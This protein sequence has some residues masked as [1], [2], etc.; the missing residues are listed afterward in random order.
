MIIL[1][2]VQCLPAN[3]LAPIRSALK[4]LVDHFGATV[5]FCTATQPAHEVASP[6]L[7]GIEATSILPGEKIA[8][9][10]HALKRVQWNVI[11]ELWSWEKV[12][13]EMAA[14]PAVP[15]L[16][17][18]NTR[19]Q[20][21]DLIAALDKAGMKQ[22]DVLHLSTLLCP[23]H[24]RAVIA[25]IKQRLED[26]KT[27]KEKRPLFLISTTV[28]EAGVD[29]SFPRL[30]RALGPLERI[31]QAAGRCNRHGEEGR[32]GGEVIIFKPEDAKAPK[33]WYA[34]CLQATQAMINRGV[35]EFDDPAVVTAYFAQLFGDLGKD[36]GEEISKAR[37][38]LDYEAVAEKFKMIQQDT[39]DVFVTGYHPKDDPEAAQRI[40]DK[41]ERNGEMT[42]RL[43]REASPFVVSLYSHLVKNN[44]LEVVPGFRVWKGSY[45][46][47]LGIPLN[48]DIS[49]SGPSIGDLIV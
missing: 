32:E 28:I 18:V 46:P 29:L 2:E 30:F 3:L 39:V 15:T 20:A 17:V 14:K 40:L 6:W 38:G 27:Q 19:Q 24:R 23:K 10:F 26:N 16:C 25:E 42:R 37:R 48:A 7:V 43:W 22:E 4:T 8:E 36:A 34:N 11:E 47:R 21:Q 12:A 33:G 1:D 35:I 9:H 45:D 44:A 31:I 49:E 41:I 13:S 5:V